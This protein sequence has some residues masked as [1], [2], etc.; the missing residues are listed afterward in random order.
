MK[1]QHS[2]HHLNLD[3]TSGHGNTDGKLILSVAFGPRTV[4]GILSLP[5]PEA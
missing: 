2:A 1:G 4:E 5:T 3:L